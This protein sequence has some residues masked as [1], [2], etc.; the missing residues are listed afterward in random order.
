M[1]E[2]VCL[3]LKYGF[4]EL[5]LVRIYARVMTPNIASAKL[6]EKLGFSLEGHRRKVNLHHRRWMDDYLYAIVK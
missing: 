1:Q 2:A 5:K 4:R 3:M 6:L